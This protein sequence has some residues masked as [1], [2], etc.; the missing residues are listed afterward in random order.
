MRRPGGNHMQEH[1]RVCVADIPLEECAEVFGCILECPGSD[2]GTCQD[3]CLANGVGAA[4]TLMEAFGFCGIQNGCFGIGDP[5][6]EIACSEGLCTGS[7]VD[8]MSHQVP[9]IGCD[10]TTT[11]L[12]TDNENVSNVFSLRTV[13]VQIGE[14]PTVPKLRKPPATP[15]ATVP[16][17]RRP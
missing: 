5:A 6:A 9:S 15:S 1:L 8:C 11:G 10:N 7:Y 14:H 2:N 17:F 4:K 16:P 3:A 12:V 13:P